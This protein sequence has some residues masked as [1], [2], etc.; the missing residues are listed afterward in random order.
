MIVHRIDGRQFSANCLGYRKC[1]PYVRVMIKGK[2]LRV[3]ID[4]GS[5]I[6][7]MTKHFGEN[8]EQEEKLK[9]Y[10]INGSKELNKSITL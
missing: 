5:S 8:K 10:T 9:V 4:T 1:C 6:K 7:L 3:M 2:L